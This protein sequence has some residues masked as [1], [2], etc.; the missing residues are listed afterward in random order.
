MV[1]EFVLKNKI[2]TPELVNRFDSVV[3]Y[4]PLR[5]EHIKKIALK[6]MKGV[7]KGLNKKGIDLVIDEPV[8]DLL[9]SQGHSFEFGARPLK[10]LIADKIEGLLARA[11]LHEEVKKGDKIKL[12]VDETSKAFK[13]IQES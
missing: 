5:L 7:I 12:V 6:M 2:F 9:A 4:K 11:M 10:R 1:E 13:I 8:F 3:V